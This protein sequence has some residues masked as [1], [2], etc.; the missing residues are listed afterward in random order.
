ML[1][2]ISK[3]ILSAVLL[4]GPAAVPAELD[5]AV[6]ER[7]DSRYYAA[8]PDERDCMG[9][10][11]IGGGG[12]LFWRGCTTLMCQPDYGDCRKSNLDDGR[13]TCTCELPGAGSPY[14][15]VAAHVNSEGKITG[16]ECLTHGCATAPCE[17]LPVLPERFY[18]CTCP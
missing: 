14:C 6:P 2:G 1:D 8:L 7:S 15:Q 12:D 13:W 9:I 11:T 18:P 4:A 5:P 16:W 10:F 17:E 3:A